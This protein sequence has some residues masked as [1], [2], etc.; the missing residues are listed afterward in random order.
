MSANSRS[1]CRADILIPKS[2]NFS[3]RGVHFIWVV[4]TLTGRLIWT[5]L[6]FLFLSKP[7]AQGLEKEIL[8]PAAVDGTS[9]SLAAGKRQVRN[10]GLIHPESTRNGFLLGLT[11]HT[12]SSCPNPTSTRIWNYLSSFG[13]LYSLVAGRHSRP[14]ITKEYISLSHTLGIP[15]PVPQ[16]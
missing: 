15:L 7:T 9:I 2:L 11:C 1:N 14:A 16:H 13:F 5:P 6:R 4:K 12:L 10:P 8:V 3:F